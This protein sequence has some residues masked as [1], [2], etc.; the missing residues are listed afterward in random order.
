MI[1]PVFYLLSFPLSFAI[2]KNRQMRAGVMLADPGFDG[3][4]E[5]RDDPDEFLGLCNG[6]RPGE[7]LHLARFFKAPSNA[8]HP[9][10]THFNLCG[11][12]FTPTRACRLPRPPVGVASC[13]IKPMNVRLSPKAPAMVFPFTW[14]VINEV[15]AMQM[16]HA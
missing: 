8:C 15:E 12:L 10:V 14:V 4:G 5:L 2:S 9:R 7:I 13:V 6:D 11:K 3:A 16:A 1:S